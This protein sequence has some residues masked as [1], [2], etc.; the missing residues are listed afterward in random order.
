[1]MRPER[2][3]H[4][5]R[6][7]W[8]MPALA[9][10]AATLAAITVLNLVLSDDSDGFARHLIDASNPASS[11]ATTAPDTATS[12]TVHL[13][14]DGL[15]LV[16]FGQPRDDVIAAL[17]KRLGKPDEDLTQPCQN[18]ANARSRWVRWADLSVIFS[19]DA[20]V[21]YIEGVHF[22]PG[23]PPLDF[24]TAKGLSPGDT[25]DRLRQ[26]YGPVPIRQETP[27]PG[28]I[29]TKVFTVSD[30][31]ASDKLSGVLE[32]QG[33]KAVVTAIFAGELC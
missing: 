24:S 5:L 9:S 17:S 29:A 16:D 19:A 30:D 3:K 21:G 12:G 8:L 28:R 10:G 4:D 20:F 7:A 26:L 14:P 27:Q 2:S 22:P 18:Q 33:D 13:E 1:M 15:D 32:G 31:K 11:R 6:W 25:V 23:S